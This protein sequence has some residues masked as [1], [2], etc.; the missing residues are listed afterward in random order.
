MIESVK[1]MSIN[2]S[3]K[4]MS[5]KSSCWKQLLSNE[6]FISFATYLLAHQRKPAACPATRCLPHFLR[7]QR[8][9]GITLQLWQHAW[10]GRSVCLKSLF[11]CL[12]WQY[13]GMGILQQQCRCSGDPVDD[14]YI[15]AGPLR[16][17]PPGCKEW[18]ASFLP[19][20]LFNLLSPKAWVLSS[21][22]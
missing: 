11:S 19:C 4:W 20:T 7:R 6:K 22:P 15:S 5:I 8:M 21:K 3:M 16:E 2:G 17:G 9:P 18:A 12:R 13:R 14:T 10:I 1:I